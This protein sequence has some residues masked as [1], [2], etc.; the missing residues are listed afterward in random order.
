MQQK[1]VKYYEM[2]PNNVFVSNKLMNG[3]TECSLVFSKQTT[4]NPPSNQQDECA[5]RT[6]EHYTNIVLQTIQK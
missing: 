1:A 3:M 5:L 6:T 2:S 4:V